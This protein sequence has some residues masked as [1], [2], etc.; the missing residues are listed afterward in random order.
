VKIPIKV[1][2]KRNKELPGTPLK[3][4]IGLKCNLDLFYFDIPCM[5]HVLLTDEYSMGKSEFK[6]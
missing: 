4:A 3:F 5:L 2:K 6:A 1:A